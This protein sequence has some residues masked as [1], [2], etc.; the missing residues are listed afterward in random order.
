MMRHAFPILLWLAAPAGTLLMFKVV[1]DWGWGDLIE[2]TFGSWGALESCLRTL[3]WTGWMAFLVTVCVARR[4]RRLQLPI[5]WWRL[6][7][8]WIWA[9]GAFLLVEPIL[10]VDAWLQ[11]ARPALMGRMLAVMMQWV[12][13]AAVLSFLTALLLYLVTRSSL[14]LLA[15]LAATAMVS[16]PLWSI[17]LSFLSRPTEAAVWSGLI[18]AALVWWG[19]FDLRLAPGL[20][21]RCGYSRAGLDAA[22]RCPECGVLPD[23]TVDHQK[24]QAASSSSPR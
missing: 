14:V 9:L 23:P 1:E 7:V 22:A 19:W 17:D 24:E 11:Q 18:F 2:R 4:R 8:I 13:V 16:L 6:A 12:M 10:W 5:G 20:C 15:A 21:T 3:P